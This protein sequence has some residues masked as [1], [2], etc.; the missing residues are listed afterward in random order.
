MSRRPYFWDSWRRALGYWLLFLG[1]LIIAIRPR[2]TEK[3]TMHF[4]LP[5]HWPKSTLIP[6]KEQNI[7]K[8]AMGH[9]ML[10]RSY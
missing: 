10:A 3:R 6:L 9:W 1:P 2:K 4:F 5:E 7:M 8:A